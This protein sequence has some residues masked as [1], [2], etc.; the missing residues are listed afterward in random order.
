[1]GKKQSHSFIAKLRARLGKGDTR[2]IAEL[3]AIKQNILAENTQI[4]NDGKLAPSSKG[5]YKFVMDVSSSQERSIRSSSNP[6]VNMDTSMSM[7]RPRLSYREKITQEACPPQENKHF[8][9]RTFWFGFWWFWLWALVVG[10]RCGCGFWLWVLVVGSGC[11][12]WL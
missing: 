9:R 8:P 6:A 1:M 7:S 12:F 5:L 4:Q 2:D 11:G 3:E 10:S